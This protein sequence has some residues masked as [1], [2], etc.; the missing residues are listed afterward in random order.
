MRIVHGAQKEIHQSQVAAHG[1]P[2]TARND[3]FFF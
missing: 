2:Q 1:P 3:G